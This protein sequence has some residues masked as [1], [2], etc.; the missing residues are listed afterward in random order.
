MRREVNTASLAFRD[1]VS[2][3]GNVDA[4]SRMVTEALTTIHLA[5][6]R[7]DQLTRAVRDSAQSNR[8]SVQELDAQVSATTAHAEAQAASSELARA[9]AEETA[10]ASQQVAA[11]ASQ[12][13]D[14][15]SRLN[16]LVTSFAV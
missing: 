8:D 7:M 13:A 10:A 12:L 5:I 14:S 2:S 3:L 1:G 6:A 4:T 9:A 15:A 11:T 16:T